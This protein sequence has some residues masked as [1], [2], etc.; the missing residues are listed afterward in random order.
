MVNSPRGR[1]RACRA[2]HQRKPAR[3]YLGH[4]VTAVQAAPV[5]QSTEQVTLDLRDGKTVQWGSPGNA[6]QKNRELAILLPGSAHQVD[7]SAKGTVV[8]S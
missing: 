4:R 6:A 1:P 3:A 8:T 5:A 2:A 7:V